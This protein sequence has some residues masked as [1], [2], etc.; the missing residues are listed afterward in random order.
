MVRKMNSDYDEAQ[1]T[2]DVPTTLGFAGDWLEAG[3]LEHYT[4]QAGDNPAEPMSNNP[5]SNIYDVQAT[6]NYIQPMLT[7]DVLMCLSYTS[8]VDIPQPTDACSSNNDDASFSSNSW[9]CST[10]CPSTSSPKRDTTAEGLKMPIKKSVLIVEDN[11]VCQMCAERVLKKMD[12][13]TDCAAHGGEAL[14]KLKANPCGYDLVLMDIA[15]PIMGGLECTERIRKELKLNLPIF[16]F[17]VDYSQEIH[18]QCS[19][20]GMGGFLSK[21]P[22]MEEFVQ[23]FLASGLL[24]R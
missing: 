3:P 18:E 23:K 10:T 24:S 4:T 11:K 12:I 13:L 8:S 5:Q 7:Q 21:P 15:M 22:R 19:A 20:L 1:A 14:K 17:T 6:D 16:A 2:L 9:E